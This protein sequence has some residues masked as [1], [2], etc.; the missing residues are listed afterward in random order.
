M[1]IFY[2]KHKL[3]KVISL[4]VLITIA[5]GFVSGNVFY[6]LFLAPRSIFSS[7]TL[8]DL[9]AFVGMCVSIFSF[10][11][12]GFATIKFILCLFHFEPQVIITLD[13]IEDKRFNTGAIDWK[14]VDFVYRAKSELSNISVFI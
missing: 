2:S 8:W 6:G 7:Y 5:A 14:D 10:I 1:E 9:V 13:T 12:S 4:C 3:L 11:I